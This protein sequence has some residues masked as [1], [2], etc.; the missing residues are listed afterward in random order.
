MA[1]KA[2]QNVPP[3]SSLTTATES[4]DPLQ[5]SSLPT[6]ATAESA[7]AKGPA[8]DIGEQILDSMRAAL[9]R[10]DSEVHVRLCPPE[11]GT[12]L[13]RF[14]ENSER[15]SGLLEVSRD[16]TRRE[17]ERALPDVVRS[18][19]DAGIRVE[20]LEVVSVSPQ[21]RDFARGQLSQD[22]WPQQHKDSGQ[23]HDPFPTTS[24]TDDGKGGLH[25]RT[26]AEEGGGGR[27]IDT[28]P[29]RINLLL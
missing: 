26:G 21:E 5:R 20:R 12:V 22:A 25:Y 3:Q 14:R 19:Q 28:A 13:V 8:Q 6:A 9:D 29:G 7:V 2:V 16:D 27:P 1:P 23:T 11:L 4:A 17:I 18:L 15:I 24:P 10:A